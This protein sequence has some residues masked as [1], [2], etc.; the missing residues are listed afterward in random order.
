MPRNEKKPAGTG[1]APVPAKKPNTAKTSAKVGRKPRDTPA[2]VTAICDSL[3]AG[4]TKKHACAAARIDEATLYK[5]LADPTK[6]ALKRQIDE[7]EAEAHGNAAKAVTAAFQPQQEVVT[8]IDRHEETRLAPDGTPYQH[9]TI[10][11]KTTIRERPG[12]WRAGI[13]YLRRR[14]RDSWSDR[15]EMT[16]KDGAPLEAVL[17]LKDALGADDPK[18]PLSDFE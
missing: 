1:L 8:V 10:T 2:V 15:R 6:A 12:D 17:T 3:R 14:D 4:S 5:W 18:N 9:V 13:E 7:A 11:E 16:G